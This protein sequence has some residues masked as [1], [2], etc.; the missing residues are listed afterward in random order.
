M[1]L[2]NRRKHCKKDVRTAVNAVKSV[3]KANAKKP[4]SQ[5]N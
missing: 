5:K 4:K 1:N 2:P 3:K